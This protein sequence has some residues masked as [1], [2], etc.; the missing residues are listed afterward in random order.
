MKS[1]YTTLACFLCLNLSAQDNDT[2]SVNFLNEHLQPIES[3]EPGTSDYSDLS[4]LKKELERVEIVLLGEQG[5]GDGS[6]FLAKTRLIK[7]L[8]EEMGYN[9]LAFESGLADCYRVWE[10]IQNGADSLAVFDLGIFPVWAKSKQV[11]PLFEY[12]LEQSKTEHPLILAG[13]D[14]QPTGSVLSPAARYQEID[15]YLTDQLGEQWKNK[16]TQFQKAYENIP[17][18]FRSPLSQAEKDQLEMEVNAVSEAILAAGQSRKD[19]V[20]ARYI[21]N[22]HSTISLFTNAD[23]QNPSNT[24]HVFNIRDKRMAENFELIM[25]EL[26]P[27][28]KLIAWGANSHLGFGRALLGS[29]EGEEAP[30]QAMVPAGQYLKI[31]YQDR[32][33]SIAF[34]SAGGNYGSMN[35]P[36]MDLGTA[37]PL[38]LEAQIKKTG[39]PYAFLSLNHEGLK[40]LRFA[41][42]IYGHGEMSG[43]WSNMADAI[44]YIERM[45]ANEFKK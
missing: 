26:Y 40:G 3:I 6:S 30:E 24:P 28:E 44:F 16:Y 18:L 1:I 8:H 42:R 32:L 45:E 2:L 25:N 15:A 14:M 22:L 7:Y 12:I 10:A 39:M 4:F 23:M 41:A 13:F 11:Q 36:P 29:F 20:M 37:H 43:I 17:R 33:Y 38:S 5:H 19:L 35:R 31:D 9:V 21:Q 27:G 34:T